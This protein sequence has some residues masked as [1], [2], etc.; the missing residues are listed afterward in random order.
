MPVHCFSGTFGAPSPTLFL[1]Y[2][3]HLQHSL[4]F[5]VP[6]ACK[7]GFR[8]AP[9]AIGGSDS[10]RV[11]TIYNFKANICWNRM[12]RNVFYNP[13]LSVPNTS[14]SGDFNHDWAASEDL[15]LFVCWFV[16]CRFRPGPTAVWSAKF[17]GWNSGPCLHLVTQPSLYHLGV[18]LGFRAYAGHELAAAAGPLRL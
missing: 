1:W 8:G 9:H 18:G 4:F 5:R 12:S 3:Q 11:R 15:F 17:G 13:L 14:S 16:F 6:F 2:W 7:H 10:T